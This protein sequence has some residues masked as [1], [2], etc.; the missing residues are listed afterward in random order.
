M[1]K[2]LHFQCRG[3][4][5]DPQMGNRYPMCCTIW[6]KKKKKKERKPSI[7]GVSALHRTLKKL[8][9]TNIFLVF[10]ELSV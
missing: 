5:F 8:E 2:I 1:V 6:P 4:E 7:Y 10:R 3:H 9:K